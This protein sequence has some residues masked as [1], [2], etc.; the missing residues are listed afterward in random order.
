MTRHIKLT[1]A[2]TASLTALAAAAAL[3]APAA[4]SAASIQTGV[5][6]A[7]AHTTHADAALTRAVSLFKHG[8]DSLGTRQFAISQKQL[9]L[10]K[11][12]AA[13][14]QAQ[15]HTPSSK[16]QAAQAEIAVATQEKVSVEKLST[17]VP[18]A[19]GH[20]Q[21]AI[22][23][24]AH[25]DTSGQAEALTVLAA[26]ELKAPAQAQAGL[27]RAIEAIST[28]TQSEVSAEA[29][30]AANNGDS[31]TSASTL[32][33]AV[34]AAVS[35]QDTASAKLAALVA[36]SSTPA[37]ALPG[38]QKAY[39]EVT[40]QQSSIANLLSHLSPNMPA[41]VRS[42]VSAIITQARTNASQM[43]NNRPTPPTGGPSGSHPTG[44]GTT[45]Q[46]TTGSAP[47]H[48]TAGSTR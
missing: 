2:R 30:A 3:T 40:A 10:A 6:A 9:G 20:V 14:L 28:A 47:S 25:S 12:E 37:A 29:K 13:K 24:A 21:N 44:G 4:A 46:P 48:P 34:K 27:A 39:S 18:S 8:N 41:S 36:S 23:Q 42:F 1:H 26:V 32:A 22:A 7:E 31:T 11:A 5:S 19:S 16:A 17:L 45:T 33:Q 38:L 35:G 15:A 43:K